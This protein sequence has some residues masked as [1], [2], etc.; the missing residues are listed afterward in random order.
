MKILGIVAEYDPFHRGHERHLQMAKEL[1]QPDFTWI[2]LSGCFKQRGE[3]ALLDPYD[4]AECALSCG[5]DAVFALP[6]I[7]TIRDAEH[8]TLGAVGLLKNLGITHLAFGAEETRLEILQEMAEEMEEPSEK[9]QRKLKELLAKGE[10]YP[11]AL[12]R[13]MGE[14]RQEYEDILRKPNNTLALCYLRAIRKLGGDIEPVLIPREGAYHAEYIDPEQPSAS[15]VREALGQGNY[16]NAYAALPEFS[17]E[18]VRRAY[19]AEKVPREE[20]LDHLLI[21][22]LREMTREETAGLPDIS[23]GLDKRILDV[24]GKV[25]TRKELLDAVST[26]RY[27]RARISR[28]CAAALLEISRGQMENIT[29]PR[30]AVMLGLR[31][32]PEMTALWKEREGIVTTQWEEPADQRA[33]QIWAQCAGMGD[34][35]PW[36]KKTVTAENRTSL[37]QHGLAIQK[38]T[39]H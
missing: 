34:T 2:V 36:A 33:W 9:T 3:I 18:V 11:R 38:K 28:I 12:S 35:L 10:G 22:R 32:N 30:K 14:I 39:E 37:I 8:Y 24:A 5:A 27:P 25:N 4:R 23:E 26:R 13:A 15:A 7:W 29:M 16:G 31:K 6:V 19:L 20:I 21:S 17:R 1:V